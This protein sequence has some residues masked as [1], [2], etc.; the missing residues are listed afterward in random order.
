[1]ATTATTITKLSNVQTRNALIVGQITAYI[2]RIFQIVIQAPK[3]A[4]ICIIVYFFIIE[5]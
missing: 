3:L 5:R 1:M 4:G 2:R